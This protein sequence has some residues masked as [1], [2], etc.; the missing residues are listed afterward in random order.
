[1]DKQ[2]IQELFPI[3]KQDEEWWYNECVQND[4]RRDNIGDHIGQ[5]LPTCLISRLG[6]HDQKWI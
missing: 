1:V 2:T 6:Y 4:L 5:L 3:A